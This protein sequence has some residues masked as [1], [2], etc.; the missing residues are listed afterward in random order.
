MKKIVVPV[1]SCIVCVCLIVLMSGCGKNE[2]TGGT[3]GAASGAVIGEAVAGKKDKATGTLV[4]ALIGGCLGK[5]IGR[6]ADEE[7]REEKEVRKR[8][9]TKRHIN[10]LQAENRALKRSVASW[11][12]SCPQKVKILGARRC[13]DCGDGLIREKYCS[14]CAQIFSPALGHR[15]CPYCRRKTLLSCR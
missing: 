12:P 14:G 2:T 6:A 8:V 5:E 4:G 3:I 13:P 7:E 1:A 11:C 10:R 15:Y 9:A